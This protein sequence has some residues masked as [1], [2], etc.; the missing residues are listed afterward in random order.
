MREVCI[1]LSIDATSSLLMHPDLSV[2][3]IL[4]TK[5]RKKKKTNELNTLKVR[6]DNKAT[7]ISFAFDIFGI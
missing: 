1:T 7:F 5:K 2:S 4:L 6:Y 3:Y